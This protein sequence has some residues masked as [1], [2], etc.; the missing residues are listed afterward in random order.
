MR[1]TTPPT[2]SYALVDTLT[3]ENYATNSGTSQAPM[4]SFTDI[5]PAGL[6]VGLSSMSNLQYR[7][8]WEANTAGQ[9][10]LAL[11]LAQS[12]GTSGPLTQDAVNSTNAF[13]GGKG[14]S[15]C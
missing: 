10:A 15:T 7:L 8:L 14:Y 6:M 13:G 9:T 1:D 3:Q 11:V 2:I 12:D 5:F 4:S